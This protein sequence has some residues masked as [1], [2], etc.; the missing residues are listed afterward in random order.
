MEKASEHDCLDQT[1]M[2]CRLVYLFVSVSESI[3]RCFDAAVLCSIA[4]DH[5]LCLELIGVVSIFLPLHRHLHILIA[6]AKLSDCLL[7]NDCAQVSSAGKTEGQRQTLAHNTQYLFIS[8]A[9]LP[10]SLFAVKTLLLMAPPIRTH[11]VC[12]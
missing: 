6:L 9:C 11:I 4:R 7:I 3:S 5:L 1:Q 12:L 10:F 2:Y 8:P